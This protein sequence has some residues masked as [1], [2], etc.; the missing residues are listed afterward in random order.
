MFYISI[1]NLTSCSISFALS[2]Q[3]NSQSPYFNNFSTC[4]LCYKAYLIL[5]L[6]YYSSF[7]PVVSY[8]S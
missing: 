3:N 1:F 4:P 5:I 8:N 6:L 2:S 7:I